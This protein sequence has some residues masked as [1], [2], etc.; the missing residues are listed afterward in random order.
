[1]HNAHLW[2]HVCGCI[3]LV[4]KSSVWPAFHWPQYSKMGENPRSIFSYMSDISIETRKEIEKSLTVLVNSRKS[5][6][7]KQPT[8]CIQLVV[9]T[10][11]HTNH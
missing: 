6:G 2:V 8:T 10:V 1:M 9:V 3:S 11:I 7:T 5:E 4:P